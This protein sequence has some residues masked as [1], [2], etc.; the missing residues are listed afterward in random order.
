MV[1][2]LA[3]HMVGF[4]KSLYLTMLTR[5][6]MTCGSQ[7][8]NQGRGDGSRGRGDGGRGRG[9]GRRGRGGST[10]TSSSLSGT[11]ISTSDVVIPRN[12]SMTPSGILEQVNTSVQQKIDA[13]FLPIK[14]K[15]TTALETKETTETE[16]ESPK[17][18]RTKSDN[19]GHSGKA[20]ETNGTETH[21]ERFGCNMYQEMQDPF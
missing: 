18:K 5:L 10:P 15:E 9:N 16:S 6:A 20:E 17:T 11:S 7:T 4:H 13:S 8:V 21:L 1:I 14:D 2:T 3:S 19:L 12:T